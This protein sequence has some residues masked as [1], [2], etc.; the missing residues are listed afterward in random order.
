MS[1]QQ[2]EVRRHIQ[3]LDGAMDLKCPR[4]DDHIYG[5]L[6]PDWDFMHECL[7]LKCQH[8][9]CG[10]K[11]CAWCGQDCGNDNGA[12]HE[13]VAEC[14]EKPGGQGM[15]Y[16]TRETWEEH[17]KGK[18]CAKVRTYLDS[19]GNAEIRT[20]AAL[21]QSGLLA[22]LGVDVRNYLPN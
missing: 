19:I 2:R 14:R 4:S 12:A 3:A 16:S 13:H 20:E 1:E 15:Y 21:G 6:P 17:R 9:G 18:L 7:A 5:V 10:C 8:V 22:E 11:F